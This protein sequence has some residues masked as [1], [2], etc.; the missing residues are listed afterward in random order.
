[1]TLLKTNELLQMGTQNLISRSIKNILSIPEP[2]KLGMGMM[3]LQP[4]RTLY[5]LIPYNRYKE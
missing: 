4:S 5:L 3:Q 1:M 2:H